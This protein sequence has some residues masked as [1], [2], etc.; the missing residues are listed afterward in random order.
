MPHSRQVGVIVATPSQADHICIVKLASVLTS[1]GSTRACACGFLQFTRGAASAVDSVALAVMPRGMMRMHRASLQKLEHN[2]LSVWVLIVMGDTVGS[3]G[4]VLVWSRG[5]R[6]QTQQGDAEPCH[7]M[8]CCPWYSTTCC[9]VTC[10]GWA[11]TAVRGRR[12]TGWLH[13]TIVMRWLQFQ[14]SIVVLS[15]HGLWSEM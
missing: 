15:F 10:T 4:Y 5:H 14:S 1:Q 9:G 6:P 3:V 7:C 8:A 13:L 11:R 2:M 12:S